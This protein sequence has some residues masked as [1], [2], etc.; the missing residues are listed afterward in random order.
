MVKI[1]VTSLLL[2]AST[3]SFSQD[4]VERLIRIDGG[5]KSCISDAG[6][7]I[8]TDDTA[9]APAG[10]AWLDVKVEKSGWAPKEL[11]CYPSFNTTKIKAKIGNAS[12]YI[13][14]VTRVDMHLYADCGSGFAN[15]GKTISIECNLRV[16]E[17]NLP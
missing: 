7:E 16:Q 14:A 8:K 10:K 6:T 2:T 1:L 17:I 13:D 3:Y 15:I 12:V 11:S 9:Y 4:A 5:K